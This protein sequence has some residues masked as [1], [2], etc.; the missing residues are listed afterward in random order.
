MNSLIN[1]YIKIAM[2]VI[3]SFHH[4]LKIKYYKIK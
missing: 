3:I 1:L 4:D 2:S